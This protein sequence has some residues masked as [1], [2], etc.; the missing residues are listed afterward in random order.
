MQA[1]RDVAAN[2]FVDTRPTAFSLGGGE[3]H[4]A[5]H[6]HRRVGRLKLQEQG[7]EGAEMLHLQGILAQ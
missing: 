3:E 4:Q 2:A 7:V 5:A 6:V 1:A